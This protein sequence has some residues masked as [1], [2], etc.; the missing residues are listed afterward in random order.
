MFE[1]IKWKFKC[2]SLYINIELFIFRL[3]SDIQDFKSAFK[4]CISQGLRSF[5]QV[6]RSVLGSS[7]SYFLWYYSLNAC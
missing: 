2:I 6:W 1:Y 3:T 4:L 5:T 7:D